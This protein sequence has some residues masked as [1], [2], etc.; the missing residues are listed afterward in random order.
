MTQ[1]NLIRILLL[2]FSLLFGIVIFLR[3]ILY[4]GLLLRSVSFNLPVI[5]V[6]NLSVGGAGKTP[7]IEYLI[8][9]LSP[10]LNVAV[11]S[12]GYKR[13]SKGFKFINREDNALSVGDEPYQYFIKYN[14]IKVA[15]SESRS[16]GVP[17]IV[18]QYPDTELILLDDSYQHRAVVPGLN[19]LLTEYDHPYYSD[20]LLPSGRL[21]EWP[22]AAQRADMIIVTKCPSLL[23][24][25][26]RSKVLSR[27]NPLSNQKVFFSYYQYSN[28]YN[29]FTGARIN[30]HDVEELILLTAI[31]NEAY[32]LRHLD[33]YDS[34]VYAIHYEDHHYF[35]P[36]EISQLFLQFENMKKERK[37]ILTTEKDATRLMLH[38]PYLREK[39]LPVYI[40]PIQVAFLLEEGVSFNEEIK[41]FLINFAV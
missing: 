36:H 2:P 12:R 5:G 33:Q 9:L 19:I 23:S 40:L 38:A 11:L 27:I 21:R 18:N 15:V 20:F 7:H 29:L 30:L 35:S 24:S 31:A 4:R 8:Q 1:N 3:N 32:L 16:L 17:M 6:G 39:G 34:E 26:A 13:K 14:T 28:P 41:R 25:E 10:Y 22:S 37:I